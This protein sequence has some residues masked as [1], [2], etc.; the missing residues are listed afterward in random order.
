VVPVRG[1]SR[2]P[3]AKTAECLFGIRAVEQW[4]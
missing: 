1:S 4:R 3:V 2:L